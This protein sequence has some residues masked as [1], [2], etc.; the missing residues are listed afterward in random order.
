MAWIKR[1]EIE[2]SKGNIYIVAKNEEGKYGCSCP[3][4]KFRRLECNHIKKVKESC[5]VGRELIDFDKEI[6]DLFKE[7]I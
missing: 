1:W 6:M 2:G 7:G 5:V 4:W 3:A